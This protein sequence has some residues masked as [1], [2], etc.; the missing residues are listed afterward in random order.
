MRYYSQ[1]SEDNWIASHIPL[2]DN[3]FYVDIGCA[4]PKFY[5]NTQFLRDRDWTG[6]QLDANAIYKPEWSALGLNMTVS[7]MASEN[8]AA[9]QFNSAN[10]HISKIVETGDILPCLNI[11][12]WFKQNN[13]TKIDLLSIDI[14]G[15]E[16]SVMN[17]LDWTTYKPQVI[18]SEYETMGAQDFRL[19]QLLEGKG[20]KQVHKTAVNFIHT[21]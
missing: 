18:I 11:N 5:N 15:Q 1:H 6:I 3:G 21:L 8:Q 17:T 4:Q 14:E 9:F 16:Y 7:I 20:Y 13:V 12:D 2:P 19:C 10:P